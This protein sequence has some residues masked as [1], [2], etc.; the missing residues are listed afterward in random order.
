MVA[1]S[2]KQIHRY[3]CVGGTFFSFARGGALLNFRMIHSIHIF[4]II[5]ERVTHCCEKTTRTIKM[6]S[7]LRLYTHSRIFRPPRPRAAAGPHA[8]PTALHTART[9]PTSRLSLSQ[10]EF[11]PKQSLGQN[12]L[13]DQNYVMKIC[14]HFG[15]SSEGG[16]RVLELG[17]GAGALTQA[18]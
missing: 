2:S 9:L 8:R 18:G 10:G 13:S 7:C 16:R 3:L 12:Y 4:S 6:K 5:P 17:P 15:D 11:R 1:Y 14:N